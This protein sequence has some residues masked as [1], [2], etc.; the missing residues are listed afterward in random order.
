[1]RRIGILIPLAES[2]AEAQTEVTAF[3][4][5]LRRLGWING[6]NS[7]IDTRWV[8]GAISA[9]AISRALL[10][11]PPTP[12]SPR[13]AT[14][15]SRTRLAEGAFAPYHS[16]AIQRTPCQSPP[17]ASFLTTDFRVRPMKKMA[18]ASGAIGAVILYIS[19]WILTDDEICA[20][21]PCER[22]RACHGF[23]HRAEAAELLMLERPGYVWCAH[24]NEE[25]A[26]A[27]PKTTER[28]SRPCGA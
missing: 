11:T 26:P 27:H 28:K 13:S 15:A 23:R 21:F 5:A 14:P 20:G 4:E 19:M 1:V 8:A 6:R 18:A 24:W 3:R 12:F 7:R 22:A 9:A 16:R 10:V 2:D 25:I 17:Q